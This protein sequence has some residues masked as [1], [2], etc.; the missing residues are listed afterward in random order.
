MQHAGLGGNDDGLAIHVTA[1]VHHLFGGTYFVGQNA[2]GLGAFGMGDHGRVGMFITNLGDG[3]VRP[4]H[5]H[6]TVAL[7]QRHRTAGL[8]HHP[9]AEIFVWHKE[10]ILVR[11]TLLHDFFCVAAGANDIGERLYFGTTINIGD[12]KKIRVGRL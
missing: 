9:L 3:G 6:V 11:R 12:R 4:L 7:P 8:F 2:H 1:V 10:Q 5:V